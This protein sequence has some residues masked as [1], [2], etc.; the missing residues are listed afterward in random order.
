MKRLSIIESI[1]QWVAIPV[2]LS[3]LFALALPGHAQTAEALSQ[4]K[5]IYVDTNDGKTAASEVRQRLI[6]GL[7]KNHSLEVVPDANQA[8]AILKASGEIW[9]RAHVSVN[10]RSASSSSPAYG[11]FLSAQVIGKD[12]ETLWSYLVTPSRYTSSGIRQD[13]ADQL[14]KKFLA[15]LRDTVPAKPGSGP[16]SDAALTLK[17]AGATFPA[18]LY[19]AWIESFRMRHPDIRITYDGVGSDA[20]IQQLRDNKVTF[21]ASEV[22]LSDVQM[23]EMPTKVLQF[24]T[25]IGAVVPIYHLP[26]IGRDLRFTPEVLAGIYLGK[27]HKWNDPAIR[28]INRSVTLPDAEIVVIHRGDGSGTTFAWT[29]FLSKTD[30]AWKLA[31]GSGTTVNWPIG[32]GAEGNEGIAS[33]VARTPNSI[34]YTEL[35][36]AIQR[37]LSYGTVRN[38]AGNFTQANLITLAAAAANSSTRGTEGIHSSLTNAPGKDAY[39][40]TS[41]TWL[42][43]PESIPDAATKSAVIEFLN[44]ILTS[45]QVECSALA[46]TPLPREIV[47]RELALLATFKS[48]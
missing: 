5:K 31:V 46:Y 37:E 6:D 42:L 40:I 30:S 1:F 36:Y 4:V 13:L 12:G 19:Q 24:V 9:V 41:F 14:V 15:A 11:G 20:G 3:L 26:N 44:W 25:V 32:Q 48:K 16:A 21:A 38:A 45:G 43:V 10:P 47:A 34:G 2:F 33:L 22:P 18:P 39:P 23:S 27:I 28:V 17:A 8:D 7:R 35:S 29:D